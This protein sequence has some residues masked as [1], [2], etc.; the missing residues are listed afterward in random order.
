MA[1]RQAGGAIL[2]VQRGDEKVRLQE[3]FSSCGEEIEN[4]AI[5]H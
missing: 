5:A 3:D 2:N 1:G 4:S